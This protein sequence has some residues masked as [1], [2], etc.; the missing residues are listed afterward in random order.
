MMALTGVPPT[1]ATDRPPA[2]G[3]SRQLNVPP[4]GDTE[5]MHR[6]LSLAEL[7]ARPRRLDPRTRDLG[8][9]GIAAARAALGAAAPLP[10]IDLDAA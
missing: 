5:V 7:P 1:P 2:Q 6:Q 9:Q 10:D 3:G 8:R 4:P